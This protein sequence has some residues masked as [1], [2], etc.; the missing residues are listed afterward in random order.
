[1]SLLWDQADKGIGK[2][3][4]Y[5]KLLAHN[6]YFTLNIFGHKLRLCARCSGYLLG[7]LTS[8]FYFNYLSNPLVFLDLGFQQQTCVIL[9][10]PYALDWI[11]QSW[12]FRESSNPV[13]LVTGILLGVD[14][15]L[16]S[17]IGSSL[18]ESRI[19]F[20]GGV[21]FVAFIGYLGKL[22]TGYKLYFARAREL[23]SQ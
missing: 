13:R 2:K 6:H 3:L 20:V 10:L 5:W 18:Q 15:I 12:G 17:S 9:A 23:H 21:L 7:I 11:T 1:M 16:F 19:T 14:L 4:E 22:R 8:I